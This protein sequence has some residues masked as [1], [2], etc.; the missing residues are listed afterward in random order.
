MPNVNRQTADYY[1]CKICGAS[2]IKLWRPYQT[3]DVELRCVEC[4]CKIANPPIDPKTVAEDGYRA[5]SRETKMIPGH[6]RTCTLDWFVP[7]IPAPPMVDFPD[8]PTYWGYTSVPQE[9]IDWW[10]SIPTR[11]VSNG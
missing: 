1:K 8:S 3:F 10:Q 4:A 5:E 11:K 2:G 9:D 6:D 7:A